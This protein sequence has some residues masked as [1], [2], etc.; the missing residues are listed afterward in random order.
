MDKIQQLTSILPSGFYSLIKGLVP[1]IILFS[2]VMSAVRVTAAIEKKEKIVLYKDIKSLGYV[3]YCFVLFQLV[4]TSDYSSISNNFIPFREILR[5]TDV[6]DNLFIRNVLGNIFVFIPFGFLISDLLND[7][8]NKDRILS[9]GLIVL[10]TSA[11]VEFIQM[12]IG[13]SFDI[14]DI[15]LNLTGG[16]IGYFL[17]IFIHFIYERLPKI[18]ENEWIKLII[19]LLF[20]TLI[21]AMGLILFEVVL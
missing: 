4:T 20:F 5:Y 3:V 13:R 19:V 16:I 14:D 17:Y 10:I 12:F 11:S 15:I 9:T 8:T 21:I 7:R 18:F 6:T 1:M 2:V